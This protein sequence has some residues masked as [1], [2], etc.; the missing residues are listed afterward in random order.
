MDSLYK[1][2]D[3]KRCQIRR[4]LLQPGAFED[5]LQARLDVVSLDESPE[6]EALSYVWGS[7]TP[8][9]P[10]T[11]NGKVASIGPN[12][13]AALRHLRDASSPR[14]LVSKLL[15]VHFLRLMP[16]GG[17]DIGG[18]FRDS[19]EVHTSDCIILALYCHCIL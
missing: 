4:L 1:Q 7:P 5:P 6:H 11:L 3:S 9:K 17:E 2:L 16:R 10:I 19:K 13:D 12:L 15:T 14:T 8:A 18:G